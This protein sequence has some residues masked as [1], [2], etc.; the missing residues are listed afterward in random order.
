MKHRIN[1]KLRYR[2][3]TGAFVSNQFENE[4]R[5]A[6]IKEAERLRELQITTKMLQ[7]VDWCP[8]ERDCNEVHNTLCWTCGNS[9]EGCLIDRNNIPPEGAKTEI[10]TL[11]Y[12]GKKGTYHHVKYCPNYECD[13]E[14][15]R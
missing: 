12:N 9:L 3:K 10:V 1:S 13:C 4:Y 2:K 11:F 6:K 15:M 8:F 5:K 7:P 14:I